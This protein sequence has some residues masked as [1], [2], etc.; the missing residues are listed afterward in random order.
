[1]CPKM[2]FWGVLSVK[3]WKYCP[4]ALKRHYPA[5]IRVC[6]CIACQNR[7]NGLSSRSI[8]RF[9][10]TQKEIKKWVV[11]GYM[12]RSNLWGN[13]DHMW[14]VRRYR[15]RNHVCNIWWLSAKGCGCGA[16]GKFALSH[17]LD[18]SLLQHWSHYRVTVWLCEIL[19]LFVANSFKITHK[20]FSADLKNPSRN[21][22]KTA[23]NFKIRPWIES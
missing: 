4:L 17:W 10:R 23:V 16:R 5:W 9:L 19:G 20:F 3:M 8:E 21:H 15:G 2:G 13:F 11:T 7:F 22:T 1:M 14:R 18:A 12:G 6:W